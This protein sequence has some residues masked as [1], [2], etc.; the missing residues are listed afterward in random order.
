MK[1]IFSSLI[2]L[3]LLSGCSS[4]D[5]TQPIKKGQIK[6]SSVIITATDGSFK[7]QGEFETPFQSTAHY[8]SMNL[9]GNKMIQGYFRA[10]QYNAKHVR[11][12]VPSKDKELYG[13]LV[14]DDADFRAIGSGAKS[15]KIIIPQPYVDAATNGKIS[16]VYEYYHIKDDSVFDVDDVKKYS[17]ILWLSDEDVF[18]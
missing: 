14:L 18:N 15:Y 1:Y 2:A 8:H 4:T 13:V 11:V 10:L 12:K 5:Y 7:I 9:T 3:L 6:D 16:V 17:W